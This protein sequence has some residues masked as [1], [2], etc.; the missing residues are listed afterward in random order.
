MVNI[1]LHSFLFISA[2]TL[3]TTAFILLSIRDE[4]QCFFNLYNNDWLTCGPKIYLDC[5]V[6]AI[7]FHSIL[8]GIEGTVSTYMICGW[9]QGTSI[10]GYVALGITAAFLLISFI[11]I[12][13]LETYKFIL[14]KTFAGFLATSCLLVA[15]VLMA[16]D[17]SKG[18]NGK[19]VYYQEPVLDLLSSQG[20]YVANMMMFF[21][22]TVVVLALTY[23][24]Y[25]KQMKKRE[26]F[27]TK[28]EYVHYHI[29]VLSQN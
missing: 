28:G 20:S 3:L 1:P 12:K 7:N 25:K 14:L 29:E 13:R 9:R 2:L 8:P 21:L 4:D 10:T 16:I 18:R 27:R 11:N 17:I 22:G 24:K 6:P 15:S 23:S 5:D 19:L 26:M